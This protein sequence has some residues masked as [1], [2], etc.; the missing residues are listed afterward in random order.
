MFSRDIKNP[1]STHVLARGTTSDIAKIMQAAHFN[2]RP[3]EGNDY[4][5]ISLDG[6][7]RD[8]NPRPR[9]GNDSCS[10]E[11][12][13]KIFVSFCQIYFSVIEKN[14]LQLFLS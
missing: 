7:K 6:E 2:P 14:I 5:T 3:R 13:I 8:F 10:F 9:E 4:W 12:F 11:F 1:I